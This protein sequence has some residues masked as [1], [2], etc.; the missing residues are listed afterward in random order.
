MFGARRK[1]RAL[2]G[3]SVAYRE[4][5]KAVYRVTCLCFGGIF[6]L[7]M[8]SRAIRSYAV[9]IFDTEARLV[10]TGHAD[11]TTPDHVRGGSEAHCGSDAQALGSG[12]EIGQEEAVASKAT[13]PSIKQ[14]SPIW[15]PPFFRQRFGSRSP[16]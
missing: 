1:G 7:D 8:Q 5:Y 14:P 3:S 9:V 12:E 15:C 11:W 16:R 4:R 2:T 6:D 13:G 10:S